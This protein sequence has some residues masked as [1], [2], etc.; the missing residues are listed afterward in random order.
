MDPEVRAEF[1]EFAVQ[2]LDAR[3]PTDPDDVRTWP[4]CRKLLD[5]ALHAAEQATEHHVAA[6]TIAGLLNRVGIHLR[7]ASDLPRAKELL[8]RALRINE[9]SYG[10]DHPEVARTLGNLGNVAQDQGD[11][12]ER[13]G[14]RS[15]RCGSRRR[16]TAPT[17]PR[18]PPPWATLDSFW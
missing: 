16:R 5:H 17:I 18:W 9:A 8:W 6:S 10:P 4:E 15:G 7:A 3:F 1:A 14:A 12:A 11:L 2:Q 13:G